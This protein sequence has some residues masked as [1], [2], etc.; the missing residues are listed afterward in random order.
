MGADI[1]AAMIAD[2]H[3]NQNQEASQQR[4]PSVI[5]ARTNRRCG[6]R[7]PLSGEY[8]TCSGRG[9]SSGNGLGAGNSYWLWSTNPATQRSGFE[10][11]HHPSECAGDNRSGLSR[12]ATGDF[13]EPGDGSLWG[14]GGRPG[15]AD[16]GGEIRSSRVGRRR[17]IGIG[18]RRRRVWL[19]GP[20]KSGAFRSGLRDFAGETAC[21]RLR[22]AGVLVASLFVIRHRYRRGELFEGERADTHPGI[23]RDRHDA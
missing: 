9:A 17:F 18:T 23:E 21:E 13:A 16:G 15:C 20:L 2:S 3:A 1:E 7:Y 11:C 8:C 6:P 10:A 22:L 5:C 14:E 12:G 19:F 4:H